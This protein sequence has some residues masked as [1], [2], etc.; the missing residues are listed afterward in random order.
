VEATADKANTADTVTVI[1]TP[2]VRSALTVD[3]R[4]A[5]TKPNST[6]SEDSMPRATLAIHPADDKRPCVS[7]SH[8]VPQ[9]KAQS[10]AQSQRP[11]YSAPVTA[12]HTSQVTQKVTHPSYHEARVCNS[13]IPLT[14]P[15]NSRRKSGSQDGFA[16]SRGSNGKEPNVSG[17]DCNADQKFLQQIFCRPISKVSS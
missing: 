12:R 11:D 2:E 6:V 8:P 3:H 17:D 16:A 13:P 10:K 14:N 5:S 1:D 9:P 15:A 4:E 7:D